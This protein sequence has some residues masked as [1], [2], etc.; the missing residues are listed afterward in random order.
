MRRRSVKSIII[1]SLLGGLVFFGVLAFLYRDDIFQ[2]FQDPG[3]PFQ[4][5]E[6]PAPP[7]Y[8][9]AEGWIA[10]PDLTADP[11]HD[12]SE[13]DVFVVVPSIYRGG[14][15]WNLPTDDLRRRSRLERIIRP[16]Y[17][18]PYRSAGRVF[19]PH[20]RQASIYTFMTN[21]EDARRAQDFAY[22]DVRR[23]F[24]YF[25]KHSPPE[26]P[27]ILAGHG[28]GASHAQ[29][30]LADF[31]QGDLKDR[32][33]AAYIIDHPLPLDKFDTALKNLVP[34]ETET[35]TRCVVAFGAFMPDDDVIAQRFVTRLT[36]YD[37][38]DYQMVN[39]RPL[40]CTNPLLWNRSKDYAPS[41]L[42]LGGLAAEGIDLDT[43][44]APLVKQAGVQCQDGILYVDQ[45][46]SKSLRRPIKFGGKFRTLRSNL[47]YE[48]SRVNAQKR[49]HSLLETGT[50][51]RRV[52]TLD[53]LDII[54]IIDSPVTPVK[55]D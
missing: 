29:R 28:Q 31:F 54:E 53:D 30:L 49:V 26:R 48:D 4:T 27:I 11:F 8:N 25:L 42:H 21:R 50:L 52:E 24:E 12:A 14:K 18:S 5:Y 20:Y 17:A 47:F 41:R 2:S 13:G 51:P 34:C 1:G 38:R 39:G 37:G 16:N 44:P 46:K 36:V 32:L 10:R 55:D 7:D 6:K 3:Q 35:D 23:A 19:A 45:P 40:L 9:T 15:H 22:Q 33:A 43:D